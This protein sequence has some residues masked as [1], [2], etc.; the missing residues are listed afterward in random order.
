[1]GAVVDVERGEHDDVGG[2]HAGDVYGI[3]GAVP[4]AV[5]VPDGR[6]GERD[7]AEDEQVV[8][9]PPA[10]RG[11]DGRGYEDHGDRP[12]VPAARMDV[13]GTALA[14]D[15]G[16]GAGGHR[17]DAAEHVDGEHGQEHRGGGADFGAEDAA[18]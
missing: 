9:L 2:A 18:G 13:P 16:D 15:R 7:R 14:G 3:A 17:G 8:I 6:G 11:Q 5:L 4:P 12:V 10:Q 1:V